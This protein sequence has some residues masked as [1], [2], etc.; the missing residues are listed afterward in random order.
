MK[1]RTGT[2]IEKGDVVDLYLDGRFTGNIVEVKNGGLVTAGGKP[3][4]ASLLIMIPV[5]MQFHPDM[6]PEVYVIRKVEKVDPPPDPKPK[7]I[8]RVM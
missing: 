5:P 8:A 2:E 3:E 7:K 6:A 1:D 4:P